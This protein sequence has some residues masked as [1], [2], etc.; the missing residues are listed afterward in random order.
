MRLLGAK[1]YVA[2]ANRDPHA[3]PWFRAAERHF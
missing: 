1:E 2:G 3:R